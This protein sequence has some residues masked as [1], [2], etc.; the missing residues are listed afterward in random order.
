M[1]KNDEFVWEPIVND[2]ERQEAANKRKAAEDKRRAESEEKLCRFYQERAKHRRSTVEI[3]AT[4]YAM[5]AVACGVAAYFS[6]TGSIDWLAWTFGII[7]AILAGI[8]VYGF[9]RVREMTK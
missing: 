2:P 8:A 3:Q 1:S 5:G 9:G 4:K 6:G 7:G